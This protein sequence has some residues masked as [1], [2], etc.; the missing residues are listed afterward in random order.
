MTDRLLSPDELEAALRAIGAERY[1]NLH[2]FHR[3]LH[4]G[5]LNKGQVQAWALNR[6][7][8]QASI[9]AKDATLLARLPTAEL[10]REWRRRLIDHDGTEPGTGGVARWLK[11]TDGLGLDRAYVES[12]D[13]LL[14]GTRFAVEAYVHFVRDRSILEAIAS[15]LTELFSPTIISER[16]SGMLRN[17][18]FITE[19][20]LAYFAPRLTQAPQD[21]AFAL[22]YVKEHARTVEQQQAVLN[23][24]KFKCG[25]L[26][27]MLDELDYAYVSPG[28][29]PPGAFRPQAEA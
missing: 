17:Y 2:P 5:K 24:L 8:Y 29:I 28:N 3:A 19:E 27:S 23:A 22:A 14:P 13:G 26:W 12:L 4:G 18:S 15:S 25:V 21:S 10:R 11:L 6:Y 1:H 9:P 7:Y 16:V 20:T